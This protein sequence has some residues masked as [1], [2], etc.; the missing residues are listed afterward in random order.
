MRYDIKT[1][2]VSSFCLAALGHI[3]ALACMQ[4]ERV[5]QDSQRNWLYSSSL[6]GSCHVQSI[7]ISCYSKRPANAACAQQ[8]ILTHSS[9]LQSWQDAAASV[10]LPVGIMRRTLLCHA[11]MQSEAV[12]RLAFAPTAMTASYG[13]LAAGG[14]NSS[15]SSISTTCCSPLPGSTNLGG[16][17]FTFPIQGWP[18]YEDEASMWKISCCAS[19]K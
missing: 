5:A 10:S 1:G 16:N 7:K 12:Q 6:Q 17:G 18:C 19:E 9:A 11:C 13:Y 8:S 15:V 4:A 3:P 14:Q 2:M